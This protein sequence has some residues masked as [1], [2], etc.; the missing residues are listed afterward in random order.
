M[1]NNTNVTH[2]KE[3]PQAYKVLFAPSM[4]R[5]LKAVAALESKTVSQVLIDLAEKGLPKVTKQ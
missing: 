4:Y 1:A 3:R 5:Q 2:G